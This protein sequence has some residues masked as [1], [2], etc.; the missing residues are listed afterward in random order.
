MQ[1]I[2]HT[3][4]LQNIIGMRVANCYGQFIYDKKTTYLAL[5]FFFDKHVWTIRQCGDG[6]IKFIQ[7]LKTW[8]GNG[9]KPV[10]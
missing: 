10:Y 3:Y 8:T 1:Y 6:Q 5:C 2:Q 9:E 7:Q 4:I